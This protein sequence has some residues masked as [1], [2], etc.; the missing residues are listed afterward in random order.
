MGTKYTF[1]CGKCGYEALTSAGNDYGMHAV[2]DT[3]ICKSCETIVD[4]CVGEYGQSY[5]KEEII[6]RKDKSAI[7]LEFFVC[8][9]C[10]TGDHLVKWSKWKR[11]CPKCNG[12]MEK[13]KKGEVICW[14]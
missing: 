2:V 8:P 3:Y 7:N 13:D 12:K 14:D 11:T 10:G 6:Q 5:S 9:D 1:K 4:V